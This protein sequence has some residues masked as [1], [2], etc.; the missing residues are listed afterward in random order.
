MATM[1]VCNA[2]SAIHVAIEQL[3]QF[4]PAVATIARMRLKDRLS[5]GDIAAR[6]GLARSRVDEQWGFARAWIMR[7]SGL[8][9]L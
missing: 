1:T 2:R 4:D 9:L 5:V 3:E 6:L 8:T 7:G